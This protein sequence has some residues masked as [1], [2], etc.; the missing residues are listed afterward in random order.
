M[1][2]QDIINSVGATGT[3]LFGY[4]GANRDP[5]DSEIAVYKKAKVLESNMSIAIIYEGAIGASDTA[6]WFNNFLGSRIKGGSLS[7]P[8]L[9]PKQIRLHFLKLDRCTGIA[10]AILSMGSEAQLEWDDATKYEIDDA[11]VVALLKKFNLD[12]FEFWEAALDL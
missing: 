1:K 7:L 6:P 8:P 10:E 2:Y 3:Q 9:S 11:L 5:L 12:Q 4:D